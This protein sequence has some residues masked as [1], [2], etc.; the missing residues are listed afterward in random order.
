MTIYERLVRAEAENEPV[1]VCTLIQSSGSTPRHEGSKMLVFPSGEIKGSVGGGEVEGRVINEALEALRDGKIRRLN[2]SMVDPQK[3]DPGVCGG[4]VEIII[5]P[6]ALR[7]ELVIIG[8]GHV[9]KAVAHVGRWLGFHIVISDDRPEFCTKEANPD[10]DVFYPVA[11]AELSK[12]LHITPQTYLILT[13]RSMTV[14]ITGL[15][16]LLES[17]AGYIGIIGSKRRWSLT[18]EALLESGVPKEKIERI[19]SPVGLELRAETPEEIAVS[20]LAEI[21]M[22]KNG[23]SGKSMKV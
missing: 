4:Q 9:G 16:A 5:E 19:H 14:D 11:M 7:E 22:L 15:P 12:Q 21:I 20:I 10:G 6:I 17:D 13:T 2:Y 3:G 8:G 1:A 18:R 23:G